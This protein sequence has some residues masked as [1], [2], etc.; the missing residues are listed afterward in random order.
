MLNSPTERRQSLPTDRRRSALHN[1]RRL[2]A[3]GIFF[4]SIGPQKRTLDHIE[5][6]KYE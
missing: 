5:A 3:V 2:R 6:P 1:G 4:D